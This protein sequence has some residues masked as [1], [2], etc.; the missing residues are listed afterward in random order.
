MLAEMESAPNKTGRIATPAPSIVSVRWA[1]A[2]KAACVNPTPTTAAG[3]ASAKGMNPRL[4]VV[5]IVVVL[6]VIAVKG[7][8][9]VPKPRPSVAMV[10]VNRAKTPKTVAATVVAHNAK[11]VGTTDAKSLRLAKFAEMASVERAKMPTTAA[12]IVAVLAVNPA[13]R[14]VA[15]ATLLPSDVA[16]ALV[17]PAKI[18]A[19]AAKIAA[20]LAV[21]PAKAE[22]AEAKG[23]RNTT[24]AKSVVTAAEVMNANFAG[25]PLRVV[26][27]EKAPSNAIAPLLSVRAGDVASVAPTKIADASAIRSKA[28]PMIAWVGRSNATA[29]A[30]KSAKRSPT[31]SMFAQ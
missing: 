4:R 7:A 9:V 3:M 13:V 22:A 14:A 6:K 30:E 19:T 1:K 29:L 31:V 20:V 24:V 2:A 23:V 25:E 18:K 5:W 17:A 27:G 11:N 16:M 21:N 26:S 12:K 8:F 15:K 28:A 10:L